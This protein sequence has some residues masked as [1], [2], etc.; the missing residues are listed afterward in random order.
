MKLKCRI[1]GQDYDIVAGATFS[2]EYNETLDSGSIIIDQI[3]KF[4]LNPYD[5][6]FIWNADEEFNG[7]RN[8][9][10]K[11]LAS[12][13]GATMTDHSYLYYIDN[14]GS[15]YEVGDPYIFNN[16]IC[17]EHGYG[18]KS[19]YFDRQNKVYPGLIDI[20]ASNFLYDLNGDSEIKKWNV[21]NVVFRLH[22][23]NDDT[24]LDG[25]A[26]YALPNERTNNYINE[27]FL[28]L[29]KV[30]GSENSQ[31]MPDTLY[32]ESTINVPS[33]FRYT[34]NEDVYTLRL[35]TIALSSLDPEAEDNVFVIDSINKP[36]DLVY[37]AYDY[38]Y[39]IGYTN[40]EIE[41]ETKLIFNFLGFGSS[42]SML[43]IS[44][45]KM[46][47]VIRGYVFDAICEKPVQTG[48]FNIKFHFKL[49]GE[50]LQEN[51][52]FDINV[53]QSAAS[54]W[55]AM[56]QS[57]T[58]TLLG[59]QYY[60]DK[61][62]DNGYEDVVIA[63]DSSRATDTYPTFYKHL[64]VDKRRWE[65]INLN[66][67]LY[68]CTIDLMSET[69]RLEKKVLPN[70]SI[71]QPIVGQKRSVWYYLNQFI[72]LY[73]PKVKVKLKDN[74]WVYRNKYHIDARTS[75]EDLTH[76]EYVKT[77]VHKIFTD[78]IYAPEMSLSAPT[79]R[80]LLSRLMVVKDC[81][82]IVKDDVIYA[83]KISD[84]H[85]EFKIDENKFSFFTDSM[86]SDNYSTAF[87]REYGD[88]ISQK[89]SA[90]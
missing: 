51:D 72:D 47:V 84:V 32:V 78:D 30:N 26:C 67:N 23:H 70:I 75:N 42:E 11:I 1:H 50:N 85:G 10:D 48:P 89:N 16:M 15:P 63:I 12:T 35:S 61:I 55:N 37:Y 56:N 6:V 4:N 24:G 38:N 59:T 17:D 71:T 74:T 29:T 57:F 28:V 14:E 44:N 62:I 52:G 5:D 13:V 21:P 22:I 82:P 19:Y 36:L 9:G 58:A 2:E 65:K 66:G 73:S 40:Q 25:V 41:P 49:L 60:V 53:S 18:F 46:K 20:W 80:E 69:K 45:L 76:G 77:P 83:M 3:P 33:I 68:K 86:A 34:M 54:V 43:S 87:R 81:I 39:D 88:A 31:G 7:Y 8:E 27:R 90:H 64:L 79:L